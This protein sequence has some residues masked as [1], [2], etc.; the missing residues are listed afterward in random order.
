MS[1]YAIRVVSLPAGNTPSGLPVSPG[2]GQS[3]VIWRSGQ[4][5]GALAQ[6][7]VGSSILATGGNISVLQ[8]EDDRSVPPNACIE[9]IHL[10]G[11]QDVA[12]LDRLVRLLNPNGVAVNFDLNPVAARN[13]SR[14]A[15]QGSAE[16]YLRGL[17]SRIRRGSI[18]ITSGRRMVMSIS[19]PLA[20]F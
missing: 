15:N 6:A 13:M 18:N 4:T 7:I 8:F 2:V 12:G 16:N 19:C 3:F 14:Y 10:A 20:P 5:V 1:S 11:S 9:R 17:G